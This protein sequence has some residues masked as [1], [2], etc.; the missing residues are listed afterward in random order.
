[1]YGSF[2]DAKTA[3][4][5]D[6]GAASPSDPGSSQAPL[7]PGWIAG[8]YAQTD[9][10]KWLALR[11]EVSYESAGAQRIAL[12]SG[13]APFDKYGVSFGSVNIPVLARARFPLGPGEFS[14]CLGPFLGILVGSIT[15]VDRYASSETRAVITP[16]ISHRFFFG[17][18]G[19]IG[20]SLRLG[21]GTAGIELRS[22]LSILPVTV[23][24]GQP[25]GDINPIGVH[26]VASYGIQVGGPAR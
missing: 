6:L 4:L 11:L 7:F 10:L 2:L 25:G 16:D 20:Y 3:D 26:I 23:A 1:M 15:V 13:G 22:D 17:F 24:A 5:A 12:T 19:G 14:G 18:A 9:L 8:I 21:P